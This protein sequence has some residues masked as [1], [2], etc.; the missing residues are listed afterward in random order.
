MLEFLKEIDTQVF[1]FLNS[2]HHPVMDEVMYHISQRFNWIPF[3]AFLT[4]LIFLKFKL[5]GLWALLFIVLL[6][7]LS[8]QTANILKDSTMRLRPSHNPVIADLVHIVRDR[9][10]GQFGFVSGHAANSF[11]L[12]IFMIKILKSRHPWLIPVMIVWASLKAYSRIYLGVH[13]PGDVLGGIVLGVFWALVVFWLFDLT[14]K[15]L[16]PPERPAVP[17]GSPIS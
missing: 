2:L 5:R 17:A 16:Y 14:M 6:I 4:V 10:G 15:R 13:Y 9:R 12:A 7:F 11:A 1:L 8:D 3:Y